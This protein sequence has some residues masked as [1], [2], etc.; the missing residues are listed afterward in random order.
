MYQPEYD[1]LKE[2]NQRVKKTLKMDN[3]KT[4]EKLRNSGSGDINQLT[5]LP[6]I[7][8]NPQSSAEETARDQAVSGYKPRPNRV[9]IKSKCLPKILKTAPLPPIGTVKLLP[10]PPP[11]PPQHP[12]PRRRKL[13]IGSTENLVALRVQ[14]LQILLIL[15]HQQHLPLQ[16]NGRLLQHLVADHQWDLVS[17][18]LA[19]NL[20]K[21]KEREVDD[22]IIDNF[23]NVLLCASVHQSPLSFRIHFLGHLQSFCGCYV[24]I[25]GDNH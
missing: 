1:N 12:A 17:Q 3:L 8:Q 18:T 10:H 5:P 22:F 19:G 11:K 14:E 7:S 24:H 13:V 21:E 9:L 2:E 4:K 16:S 23:H 15:D 20:K 25:A 6:P